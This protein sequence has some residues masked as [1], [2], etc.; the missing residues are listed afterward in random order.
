[1]SLTT[2]FKFSNAFCKKNL[3]VPGPIWSDKIAM[4]TQ[5]GPVQC[6]CWMQHTRIFAGKRSV[7][8][9]T[10]ISNLLSKGWGQPHLARLRPAWSHPGYSNEFS[11]SING[12]GTRMEMFGIQP[13]C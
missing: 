13:L 3:V 2:L 9:E 4:T 7:A 11:D 5:L 1:M 12:E 6:N 10:A 8:N